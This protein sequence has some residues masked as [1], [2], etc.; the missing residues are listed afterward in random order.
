M[1][2]FD[3]LLTAGTRGSRSF[4]SALHAA[5]GGKR[6]S[7]SAKTGAADVSSKKTCTDLVP[8]STVSPGDGPLVALAKVLM[9]TL[10]KDIANEIISPMMPEFEYWDAQAFLPESKGGIQPLSAELYQEKIREDKELTCMVTLREVGLAPRCNQVCCRRLAFVSKLF[11]FLG[12][13]ATVSGKQGNRAPG[14]GPHVR[15]H[16]EVPRPT[17]WTRDRRLCASSLRLSAYGVKACRFRMS[18]RS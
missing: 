10:E 4:R 8:H 12:S 13:Q 3:D 18:M 11:I 14:H 6:K 16:R 2:A 17:S 5:M 15:L 9:E 7:D 1:D